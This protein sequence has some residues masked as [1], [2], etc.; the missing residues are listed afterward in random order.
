MKHTVTLL[1]ALLL[2]PLAA[3]HAADVPQ[4]VTELWA[5]FDPRKEP[6]ETEILKSWEQDGVICRIVRYQVGVFKGVPS[7]VAAFYAFPKGG[8]KLPALVEMHGGGQSASLNSVVTYAKRGYAGISINWGGNKMNLGQETWSGPQTDWGKLDATHPPQRNKANHFAGSLTPDEYTLDAV[9]SPRNS[10]WFLVLMAARRAITFLQQQPEVDPER[11]GA[12]GHSMGG[13][14]TT[15]LAGID[16]RI[17]AAVP[18]CGGSGDLLESETNVPGG[19][20]TKHTALELACISDNAYIPLMTCPVLWLSPT[21]D[22]HAHIDNMAWNWR[23]VP[24]ERLRFSISPHLN[25]RHTDEHYITEY[26]WFEEHLKGAAFRM[27]QTPKIVLDLKSSE[28]VPRIS[29]A[30]DDSMPI[31]RVDIYYSLDPHALTRFWRDAKAA[32][33]GDHWQADCP[34]MT[35]NQPLFA[36]A[37]VMYETPANYR[38]G[39]QTAGQ[40]NSEIFAIS[41]KMISVA[42]TKLQEAGVKATDKPERL[43]DDGAR[44]WHDWYLLNW[45]HAPLWT[46]TTRKL[47]DVKWRG[48]DGASLHFEI[49]S[50]TDN[51]IVVTFNCN[52]WGAFTPGKSAV[53]YTAVKEIKGSPDW[54]SVSLS[55]N[56]LVATDPNITAPLANWQSVTEFSISPKGESVKDGQKVK[57]DGKAWKGPREIRNLRWEGGDYSRQ[58]T[59]GATL[60]SDDFQKNFNDAIKKSLDQEKLDRK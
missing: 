49:K 29:V 28:G 21:N 23:N 50:E 6:L 11:I 40:S 36:F 18:S 35:L 14:L 51:K 46:A 37:N 24:D 8:T 4:N 9:E 16:K 17:K 55:L 60:S 38:T 1:A 2:A 45:A 47:K 7:K 26:L 33:V 13:K 15:N 12:H 22:F 39:T 5:D 43:I 44:G 20:R 59:T 10:N 32:K 34:I 42:P 52:A 48:P 57:V 41:S 25:H 19:S 31:K 53:D 58:A 56:E 3:L 54:Q 30:P 27:P